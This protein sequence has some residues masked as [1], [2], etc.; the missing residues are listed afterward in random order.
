LSQWKSC[1]RRV[2]DLEQEIGLVYRLL[3]LKGLLSIPG[4]EPVTAAEIERM[5]LENQKAIPGNAFNPEMA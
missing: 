4:I 1:R 3:G 2:E 5:I